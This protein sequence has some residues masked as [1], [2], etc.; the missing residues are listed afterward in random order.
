MLDEIGRGTSTF[1][2]VYIA[3]AVAEALGTRIGSRTLFAT[4]YHELAALAQEHP[5][6]VANATV[7]VREEAGGVVFL[8]RIEEGSADRS[9]GL[10][11]AALAGVPK[12]VVER[13]HGILKVLEWKGA[14]LAVKMAGAGRAK[15]A[16]TLFVEPPDPLRE[17]LKAADPDRMTPLEALA[18]LADL[19]KR[20]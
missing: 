3:W 13:A 15:P 19:K 18:F 16:R 20:L 7:A 2:G 12:E 4:H 11:V 10:H 9:Y 14:E 6:A 1:D 5:K 17:K 8:H